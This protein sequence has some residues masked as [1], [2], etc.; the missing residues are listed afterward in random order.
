MSVSI[1]PE[2]WQSIVG[3][4]RMGCEIFNTFCFE[5]NPRETEAEFFYLDK[6]SEI[7]EIRKNEARYIDNFYSFEEFALSKKPYTL[8]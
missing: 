5:I 7:E 4:G 8:G 1:L 6:V 3:F 2:I